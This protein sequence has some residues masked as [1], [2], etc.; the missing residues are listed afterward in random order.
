MN[1]RPHLFIALGLASVLWAQ[2]QAQTPADLGLQAIND[3]A[4]INGQALACQELKA[5]GRAKSLMIAHAPKTTRFGNAYEEGTKQSYSLQIN[6]TLACPDAAT[7]SARLDALAQR[8]QTSLPASATDAAVN[9]PA[10]AQ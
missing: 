10:K 5:A 8:L 3:L 9:T 6:S 2:A 4:Q 1:H 7:L